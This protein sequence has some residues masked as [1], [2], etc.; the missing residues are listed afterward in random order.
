MNGYFNK[1]FL[2]SIFIFI[3]FVL[4][5]CSPRLHL[6]PDLSDSVPSNARL[7]YEAMK[8]FKAQH[9]VFYKSLGKAV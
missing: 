2:I 8:K 4:G 3:G 9:V 6:K 7:E 1:L 5:G